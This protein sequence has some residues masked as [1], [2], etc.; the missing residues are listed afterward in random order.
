VEVSG[1]RFQGRVRKHLPEQAGYGRVVEMKSHVL[2]LAVGLWV[3]GATLAWAQ[4]PPTQ[5]SVAEMFQL[6]VV[7]IRGLYAGDKLNYDAQGNMIGPA[8]PQA[9]TLSAIRATSVALTNTDLEVQGVRA[10]LVFS[11]T[12]SLP[13][14][15]FSL[16]PADVKIG[17]EACGGKISITIARNA[18]QP[19]ALDAALHKV[20]AFGIDSDLAEGAPDYWQAWLRGY[21]H[22][23][24]P[25]PVA[26]LDRAMH[27]EGKVSAPRLIHVANPGFSR[28]AREAG[29]SGMSL[30]GL[31]VDKGGMPQQIH[32]VAPLGMGLDEEA[33]DAVRKYRFKPAMYQGEPVPVEINI[34]VNFRQ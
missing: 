30:I 12:R 8:Q 3:C 20:F 24:S 5:Q 11:Y 13:A 14:F 10:G 28:A 32:V 19:E 26:G 29:L 34:E 22:P 27:A 16:R 18:E 15:A 7:M 4:T 31:I 2:R 21:L 17:T 6:P 9:F 33:V 1:H 23:A 25:E